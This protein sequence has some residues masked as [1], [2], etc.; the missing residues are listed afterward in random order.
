[1]ATPLGHG[2]AGYTVYLLAGPRREGSHANLAV[3]SV[4]AGILPDLDFLPGLLTGR[5]ALFHQGISH[6]FFAAALAGVLLA[7]LPGCREVPWRT[8]WGILT[9]AYVSH[10]AIDLVGPD[11]RAPYGIPL[12]WPF[13]NATFLA[14][15]TLLPGVRHAR[16]TMTGTAEWI[17][18]VLDSRNLIAVLVEAGIF[19]PLLL[20][21]R[22]IRKRETR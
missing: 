13:T 19:V 12:F 17:G 5:P 9:L 20:L 10:L 22:W 14:P 6:S 4:I 18:R 2:L 3:L 8:R 7:S 1:M 11:H 21:A 16:R 15:F